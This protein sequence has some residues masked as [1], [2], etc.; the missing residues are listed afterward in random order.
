MYIINK[1]TIKMTAQTND[2][3]PE[4]KTGQLVEIYGFKYIITVAIIILKS[5]CCCF[6]YQFHAKDLNQFY[7]L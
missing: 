5:F 4:Q 2:I 7:V 3:L 1:I 6:F